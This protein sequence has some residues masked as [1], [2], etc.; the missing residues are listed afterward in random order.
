VADAYDTITSPRVYKKARNAEA[1]LAEIERCAGA[2]FDPHLVGL[3]LDTI[4]K[5]PYPVL[6]AV[7]GPEEA[8]DT[9]L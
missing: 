9:S 3:F 2:Q 5:Q 6:E 1:A 8:S 4:R 7:S